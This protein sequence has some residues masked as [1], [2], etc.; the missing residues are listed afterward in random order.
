MIKEYM[1][2]FTVTAIALLVLLGMP[3]RNAAATPKG[4]VTIQWLSKHLKDKNLVLLDVRTFEKYEKSHIPGA[5]K[6]F[7][8]WQTMND[9]FIGFMMPPVYRLVNML[10]DFGVSN[11]SF[12][13][14]YDQGMTS[15]DTAKSARMVDSMPGIRQS[16]R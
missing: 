15:A 3:A 7:G 5:I 11:N 8:P 14:F 2:K 9:R 4:L 12:V 10:R 6:A 13:V 16:C 1:I